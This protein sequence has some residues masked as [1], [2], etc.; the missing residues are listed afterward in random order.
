M[1]A[2]GVTL[3]IDDS[4]GNYGTAVFADK[5]ST[6]IINS[7]IKGYWPYSPYFINDGTIILNGNFTPMKFRDGSCLL[8]NRGTFVANG[9]VGGPGMYCFNFAGSSVT[10]NIKAN[11]YIQNL[12]FTPDYVPYDNGYG[13]ALWYNEEVL[14]KQYGYKHWQK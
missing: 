6:V 10:G 7:D 5:D 11:T 3:T 14:V 1:A 8:M 13:G 9:E 12:D 4:S 2:P